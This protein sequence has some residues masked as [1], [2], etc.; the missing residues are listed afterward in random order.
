MWFNISLW[1]FITCLY[2][3]IERTGIRPKT[4]PRFKKIIA[5]LNKFKPKSNASL[6]SITLTFEQ[7][8]SVIELNLPLVVKIFRNDLVIPEFDHFC[9]EV[10]KLYDTLKTNMDGEVSQC[11][12]F[13]ISN[14]NNEKYKFIIYIYILTY[15][16]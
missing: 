5:Q 8:R 1:V 15:Y 6:E 12:V 3:E 2:Q 9:E 7:F 4:D 14:K 13:K 10:R 16:S 11:D